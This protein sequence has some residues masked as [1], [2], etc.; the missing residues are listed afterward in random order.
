V[1]SG[2]D[3]ATTNE[4]SQR[5]DARHAHRVRLA[6]ASAFRFV[7]VRADFVFGRRDRIVWQTLI[8]D[9]AAVRVADLFVGRSVAFDGALVA[10]GVVLHL[11][12]HR[13][14]AGSPCG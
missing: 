10:V 2:A 8:V 11:E 14:H 12:R 7:F 13:S 9:A 5:R 4:V 3:P 6:L 1:R